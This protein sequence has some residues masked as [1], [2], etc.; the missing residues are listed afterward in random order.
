MTRIA[1]LL[2]HPRRTL[3]ALATILAAAGLTVASGADFTAT[4]ANPANT[5]T[6]GTLAVANSRDD[7]AILEASG[8]RPGDA[9]TSGTVD[10]AN[11]GSLSGTFTLTRETPVDS[12]T[13][14]PLSEKLTIAVRDCGAFAG[15]DAPACGPADGDLVYSGTLAAMDAAEALGDY[16]GGEKHRFRFDVALDASAG[17]AYQGDSSAV[18]FT[19]DAA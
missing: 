19:W 8:L 4:A 12:D 17:N 10:I 2:D 16:A 13:G 11:T 5:F 15:A 9:P 3:A 7:V 18:A 6:T 14:N 1:Y